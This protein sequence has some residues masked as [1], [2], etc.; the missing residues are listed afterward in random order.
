ML[1]QIPEPSRKSLWPILSLRDI[2]SILC[3]VHVFSY[4]LVPREFSS[5]CGLVSSF[6]SYGIDSTSASPVTTGALKRF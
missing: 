2:L 4:E 1:L 6:T 3:H 5:F